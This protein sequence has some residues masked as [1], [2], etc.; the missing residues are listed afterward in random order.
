MNLNENVL[1]DLIHLLQKWC[2]ELILCI[3]CIL[4]GIF[5]NLT[6]LIDK[7]LEEKKNRGRFIYI[8]AELI[9]FDSIV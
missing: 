4:I 1:T 6:G 2:L 9:A 8:N 3:K 5:P 7:E